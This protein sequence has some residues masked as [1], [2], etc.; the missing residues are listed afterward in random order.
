[1][2]DRG[3]P[4]ATARPSRCH[5]RRTLVRDGMR[6]IELTGPLAGAWATRMASLDLQSRVSNVETLEREPR[7][8][9]WTATSAQLLASRRSIAEG[10][11][12]NAPDPYAMG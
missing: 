1:M 10:K 3:P 5:P 9:T 6:V 11:C 4:E 12:A 2:F 8:K 7:R